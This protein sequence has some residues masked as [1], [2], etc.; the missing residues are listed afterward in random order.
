LKIYMHEFNQYLAELTHDDPV[1]RGKAVSGLA[2]YSGA[3]WQGTPDAVYAAVPA[4]AKASRLRGEAPADG[5]F[6]AGATKALGNIGAESAAIVPQLLR[7]LQEDTDSRVRTEAAHGLGKLGEGAGNASR[8]LALVMSDLASGDTLR[9]EAAWALA[10]VAPLD[11]GTAPA[12]RAAADD[13]SGHVG[14]RA[15]EALWKASG[16]AGQATRA[17]ATRLDDPAVRHAAAQALNRIGPGAK[18]AVPALLIATKSADRLFRESALMALRRIDPEAAA[19]AGLKSAAV[20]NYG[21]A[22]TFK[23]FPRA[24]GKPL[25]ARI[26]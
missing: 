4:L 26:P 24:A 7:L 13:K 6:R 17:L 22:H 14:V 12:L 10:R 2:K 16:Q 9:G 1:V 20:D 11:P 18:G 5:A 3:E 19:R 8:T 23:P 15:A 21:G 25:I